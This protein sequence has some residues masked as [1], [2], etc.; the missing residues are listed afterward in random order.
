[1]PKEPEILIPSAPFRIDDKIYIKKEEDENDKLL[2]KFNLTTKQW[3]M[4]NG[5]DTGVKGSNLKNYI[6]CKYIS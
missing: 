4:C 2:L 1:M 6:G 3:S 5:M